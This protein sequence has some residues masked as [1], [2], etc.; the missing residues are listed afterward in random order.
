MNVLNIT[1]SEPGNPTGDSISSSNLNKDGYVDSANRTYKFILNYEQG[2]NYSTTT[3]GKV[4]YENLIEAFS[5]VLSYYGSNSQL[6]NYVTINTAS[7]NTANTSSISSLA[8]SITSGLTSDYDKAN[9]LFK[10]VRDNI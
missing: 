10:W 3:V 6:P 7:S 4:Q 2:P 9:A 1:V 5:R 8:T